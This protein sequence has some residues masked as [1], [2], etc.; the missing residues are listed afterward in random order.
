MVKNLP[1]SAGDLGSMPGQ[2]TETPHGSE[3][4]S[5]CT[6]TRESIFRKI[7]S[8]VQFSHSVVSDSL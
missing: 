2:G 3:Q 6:T 5:L 8:S 4:P 1:C 7:L